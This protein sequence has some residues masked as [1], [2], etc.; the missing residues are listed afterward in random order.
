MQIFRRSILILGLI[1][2]LVY[3]WQL[4]LTRAED[5][6][7]NNLQFDV[8]GGKI[9]FFQPQTGKVFVYRITTNRFSHLLT[10]EKLGKDLKKS[11]SLSEIGKEKK[12]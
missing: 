1:G 9:Y 6:P 7:E 8:D 5:L 10:L 4:N 11:R 12:D 3:F 2:L